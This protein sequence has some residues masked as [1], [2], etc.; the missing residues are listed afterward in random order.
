MH[1]MSHDK[2]SL[3]AAIPGSVL[4]FASATV[5]VNQTC[6]W[7]LG[8]NTW[9]LVEM[10]PDSCLSICQECVIKEVFIG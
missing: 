1:S 2:A 9:I 8:H 6:R 7:L 3:I 4:I 10:L 5:S